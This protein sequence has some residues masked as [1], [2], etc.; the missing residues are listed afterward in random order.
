MNVQ[1]G[2][3]VMLFGTEKKKGKKERDFSFA[4]IF[5]FRLLNLLGILCRVW[6]EVLCFSSAFRKKRKGNSFVLW[7]GVG[8]GILSEHE[9]V[10]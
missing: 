4:L 10:S 7:W 2:Y 3:W 6:R 1:M 8:T 5:C 9:N